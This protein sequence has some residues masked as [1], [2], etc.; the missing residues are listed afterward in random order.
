MRKTVLLLASVALAIVLVS[1][2]AYAASIGCDDAGDRDPDFGQCLGTRDGD[3]IRGKSYRDVIRALAGNDRVISFDGNDVVYGG[4]GN[5]RIDGSGRNDT[6][7]GGPDGDGGP[8]G[9]PFAEFDAVAE[10]YT[11]NLQGSYRHDTVYGEGGPDNIDAA[12]DDVGASSDRSFGGKGNDRIYALDGK[13]DF[14][15][16]GLGAGDV[17]RIDQGIDTARNCETVQRRVF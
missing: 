11:P 3:G 9:L 4:K 7:Y 12:A 5:D 15:N 14:V 13:E 6:I 8:A 16:C 2:V 10:G 1:G 17:A